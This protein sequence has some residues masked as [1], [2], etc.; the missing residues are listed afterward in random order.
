M[1]SKTTIVNCGFFQKNDPVHVP[2]GPLYLISS[3]RQSGIEVDF[4]DYQINNFSNPYDPDNFLAFLDR[5]SDT[6]GIG[7]TADTLPLVL[8]ATGKWKNKKRQLI[9]GGY[10]PSLAAEEILNNF[11]FVDAIV[12]GEGEQTFP[13]L[14]KSSSY[15]TVEGIAFP[16]NGQIRINPPRKRLDLDSIP[17]PAYER[18]D[19]KLYDQ[20][21]LVASR[22][23]P[24]DCTF[25]SVSPFW[26]HQVT[27]RDPEAIAGEMEVLEKK[28]RQEAVMLCDDAFFANRTWLSQTLKAI[29]RRKLCISWNCWGRI[30][31]VDEEL[32][33][34]LKGSGC[35]LVAYGVESGS[36]AVLEKIKK[37]FSVSDVHRAATLTKKYCQVRINLMWGFPFE[38]LND[39]QQTCLLHMGFRKE[40]I[41][42]GALLMAPLP[43]TELYREFGDS[44]YL[45][46]STCPSFIQP[47]YE[48]YK[49][50][51]LQEGSPLQII[52]ENRLI[53]LPF[54]C[55][56]TDNFDEKIRLAEKFLY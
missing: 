15:E 49:K 46:P 50:V 48:G 16:D 1:P 22:G 2:L 27:Y 55:Y 19:W 8:S 23:C 36:D 34:E 20:A 29:R 41:A 4:R 17:L 51:G 37:K 40:G 26:G 53:A 47:A 21:C 56:Q 6:L 32:L 45:D 3:M 42:S 13:D 39:F 12:I 11:P 54:S 14:L 35:D 5:S 44:V 30:D 25:C 38:T 24:F 10:G 52:Q 18:I 31:Q 43:G 28:Y 33:A 9:L 7:C